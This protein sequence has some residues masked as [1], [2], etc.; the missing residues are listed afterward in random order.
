MS[1]KGLNWKKDIIC[2]KG[3]SVVRCKNC[4]KVFVIKNDQP[5]NEQVFGHTWFGENLLRH[6]TRE[7][8]M[9]AEAERELCPKCGVPHGS[10]P[11]TGCNLP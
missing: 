7:D 1:A 3:Y 8:E 2:P 9:D 4:H 11:Y 5:L 6:I 10:N